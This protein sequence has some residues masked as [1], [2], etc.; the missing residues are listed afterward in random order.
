MN[1]IQLRCKILSFL[2]EGGMR[3]PGRF[4]PRRHELRERIAPKAR[5]EEYEEALLSLIA[6]GFMVA[7]YHHIDSSSG[8]IYRFYIECVTDLGRDFVEGY[9]KKEKAKEPIDVGHEIAKMLLAWRP[10]LSAGEVA[11]AIMHALERYSIKTEGSGE[12][13]LRTC[14]Y[15]MQVRI[16]DRYR[17]F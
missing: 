15:E 3:L 6:E 14:L 13:G 9:C 17:S 11:A 5:F 7:E 16:N 8:Q 10:N 4:D 1:Q 2:I 12:T